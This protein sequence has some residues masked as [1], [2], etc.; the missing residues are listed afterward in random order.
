MKSEKLYEAMT[1]LPPEMIEQAEESP[2]RRPW[3]RNKRLGVMVTAAVLAIVLVTTFLLR[4]ENNPI[5]TTAYALAEAQYPRMAQYPEENSPS[6]MAEFQAWKTDREQMKKQ[7]SPQDALG[8][9][10]FFADTAAV[11]LS[12]PEQENRIYSPINVY[13]AL[14]MV[15]ETT[16]GTGRQQ[17]LDLLHADH[18]NTLRKQVSNLWQSSYCDDGLT[19]S[20]PAASLWLDSRLPYVQSTVRT[21]AESYRAT[22]FQG[23]MG[24]NEFNEALHQ[25]LEKQTG[26]LLSEQTENLNWQAPPQN[27]MGIL[28]TLYFRAQWTN[29]FTGSENTTGVFYG[30]TGEESAEFMNKTD[31]RMYYW[32]EKFSAVGEDLN[33]SGHMWFILPDEGVSVAELLTDAETMAFAGSDGDWAHEK[34]MIVDFSVPKFDVGTQTDL[35]DNLRTLGVTEIFS[36]DADFSPLLGTAFPE[37]CISEI[38]HG[39]RVTID[40]KGCTAAAYTSIVYGAGAYPVTDRIEFRVDRPF[41]FVITGDNGLPLFMGA[42]HQLA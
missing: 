3:F 41:L 23:E 30:A 40:E 9:K 20:I 10:A 11:M 5:V 21:L 24:S 19:T 32:G 12:H 22:V 6:Y 42:I 27:I 36:A 33:N 16:D 38:Q 14:A 1:N 18:L 13:M 34:R 28:T 8:L 4:P 31:S 15:A 7:W 37:T 2:V 39:A 35:I 26:G 17:I 29:E 25:W